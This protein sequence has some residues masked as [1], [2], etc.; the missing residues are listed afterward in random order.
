MGKFEKELQVFKQFEEAF[1]G[2]KVF[3][4]VYSSDGSTLLKTLFETNKKI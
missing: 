3:G 1:A 4:E 2:T